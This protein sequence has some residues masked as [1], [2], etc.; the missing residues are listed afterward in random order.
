MD[1]IFM[2]SAKY[3]YESHLG[4]FSFWKQGLRL[5][6]PCSWLTWAGLSGSRSEGP[7][8]RT[9]GREGSQLMLNYQAG[10][11]FSQL[12]FNPNWDPLRNCVDHTLR[13]SSGGWEVEMFIY[14]CYPPGALM[15]CTFRL[16]RLGLSC[17]NLQKTPRDTGTWGRMLVNVIE[18]SHHSCYRSHDEPKGWGAS[19]KKKKESAARV[20]RW[21][22]RWSWEN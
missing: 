2:R 14:Q 20:K 11:H 6:P 9:Q 5:G 22:W 16:L 4:L 12:R 19:K 1:R 13:C 21:S 8:R 17:P 18:T 10:Y 15:P 7:W 3:W